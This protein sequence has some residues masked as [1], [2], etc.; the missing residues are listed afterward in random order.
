[1]SIELQGYHEMDLK[2]V[3]N[4]VEVTPLLKETEKLTQNTLSVL[5]RADR[6]GDRDL[7][8]VVRKPAF[9]QQITLK[10]NDKS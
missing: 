7:H 10:A 9:C 1:M 2:L 8:S 6:V 3:L 4:H 5:W